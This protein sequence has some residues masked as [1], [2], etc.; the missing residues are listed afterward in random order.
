MQAVNEEMDALI[1]NRTWELT[2]IP[3]GKR[4]LNNRWVF[5][6]KRNKDGQIDRYK[7]RL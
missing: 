6:I 7:A 5:K 1:E 2:T 3:Q 4:A